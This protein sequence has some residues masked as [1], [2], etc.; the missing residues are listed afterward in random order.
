[1]YQQTGLFNIYVCKLVCARAY[2]NI[3]F[4]H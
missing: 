2:K 4:T 3:L 1:V